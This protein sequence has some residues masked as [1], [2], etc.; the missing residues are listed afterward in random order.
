MYMSENDLKEIIVQQA[1]QIKELREQL[2]NAELAQDY[3]R[4][5]CAKAALEAQKHDVI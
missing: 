1:V 2:H 4:D 3:W 5:E